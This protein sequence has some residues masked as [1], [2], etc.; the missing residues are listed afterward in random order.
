[1]NHYDIE[2][3]KNSELTFTNPLHFNDPFDCQLDIDSEIVDD[4][5]VEQFVDWWV[6]E[7]QKKKKYLN[8]TQR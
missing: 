6:G 3:L 1:M 7:A 2:N 8:L 4:G 5:S